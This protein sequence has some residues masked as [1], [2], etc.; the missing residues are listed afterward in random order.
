MPPLPEAIITVVGVF[1]PMFSRP[2]WI[3]AQVLL[4]GAILCQGPKNGR[5]GVACA[6]SRLSKYGTESEF[7]D[8][9]FRYSKE[10][11]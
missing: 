1:A 3:H 2:V 10:V 6:G 8:P 9:D 4:V 11:E 5:S 7:F